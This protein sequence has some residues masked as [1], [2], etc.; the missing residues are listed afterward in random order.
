MAS[1]YLCDS[2]I[3]CRSIFPTM[4]DTLVLRFAA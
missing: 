3:R 1:S 2:R 4:R